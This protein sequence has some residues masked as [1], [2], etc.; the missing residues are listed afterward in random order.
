MKE[1]VKYFDNK[2]LHLVKKCL[3]SDFLVIHFCSKTHTFKPYIKLIN[4]ILCNQQYQFHV[5]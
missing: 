2:K 4:F 1:A 5:H 3:V